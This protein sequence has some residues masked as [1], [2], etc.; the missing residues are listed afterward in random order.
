M[1]PLESDDKLMTYHSWFA[2]PLL[3]LQADSRT[4]VQNGG[5]PLMPPRYLHLDLPEHVMRN[6]SKFRLRAHTL[7][8]ESSIWRSGN[9]HCDKSSCAAVQ[10]EVHVLFHCQDLFVCSLRRSTLSFSSLSANPFPWRPLIFHM[11]CLVRL[12]L[13][14]FLIGT[15]DSAI[16][17]RT[18]WTIFWLAKTSNKPISLTTWLAVNPLNLNSSRRRGNCDG[19]LTVHPRNLWVWGSNLTGGSTTG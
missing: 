10:N 17:F 2:C 13:I 7:A 9:G 4:R 18:L 19:K 5:G 3:D 14:F 1:N 8:V 12:S 6:V 15:I 16:S 11:P